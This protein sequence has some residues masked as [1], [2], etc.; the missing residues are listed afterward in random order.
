[1]AKTG[2]ENR[3]TEYVDE[4]IVWIIDD[5]VALFAADDCPVFVTA[6]ITD[7]TILSSKDNAN[8][9]PLYLYSDNMGKVEKTPNLNPEIVSKISAAVG[10]GTPTLP[11]CSTRS[12]RLNNPPSPE[13]IFHYI[14]AVL[15]TPQYRE[16]YREFLKVD[17][18]RIPY[19]KDA[20][21]FRRLAAIGERLVAVH[22][23]RDPKV[24]DMFSPH[25]NFPVA[26]SNVV[27]TVKSEAGRV[28]INPTQYFDNVPEAAWNCHIGGYQPAQKWPKDRKG[29]ALTSDDIMHYTVIVAA[30][31]ETRHL[32][33]ELEETAKGE[34]A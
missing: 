10:D 27:E 15:H 19:P 8:V 31:V 21:S 32:M 2:I 29:R 34:V 23:L 28:L 6:K 20:D 4:S 30:L 18:P 33:G 7:K 12:T 24:R 26:G 11:T 16:L 14:Y 22:L 3:L 9:F 13:D 17:F 1:M 25:A 5:L